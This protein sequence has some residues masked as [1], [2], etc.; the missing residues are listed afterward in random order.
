MSVRRFGI[1]PLLAAGVLAAGCDVQVG[2]RGVSLDIAHGNARDEWVRTY[3]IEPGGTLEIVN[4]NGQIHATAGE[5][6]PVEVRAER[7]LRTHSVEQAQEQLRQVEMREDVSPDR[8]RIR[9]RWGDGG[10]GRRGRLEVTYRVRVPPGLTVS[11]ETE[12]GDVRLQN[13]SG[14]VTAST[15]NGGITGQGLSGAVTA[16]TINGTVQID[17]ASVG[18]DVT[19]STTNGG[20]RLHLPGDAQ[21]TV[22]ANCVNGGI[23]VDER[24]NL[25]TTE[26]SRRRV[27]GVL[28]GG[29]PRISAATINGGV[30][31]RARGESGAE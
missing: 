11:L 1:L 15:T 30:R 20:V 18:G 28:N 9:S 13:L 5:A 21:A 24:L 12:N 31:I 4:A 25:Q 29:G 16:Q 6:G 10:F 26:T 27:V 8:V 22:E 19:V 3:A 14:R 7:E 2:E 17:L 23:N